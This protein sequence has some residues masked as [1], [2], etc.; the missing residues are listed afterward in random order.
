MSGLPLAGEPT[1]TPSTASATI[2]KHLLYLVI[3]VGMVGPLTATDQSSVWTRLCGSRPVVWLGEISYEFFCV[4]V[5]VLE[6]VMD[7]LDYHVFTG[8]VVVVFAATTAISIPIAW[9]LHRVT[10]PLWR[11]LTPRPHELR[12]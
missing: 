3:A 7:L 4:H 9:L 5:L 8:N 11:A 12:R 2:V 6:V 10:R 1:I